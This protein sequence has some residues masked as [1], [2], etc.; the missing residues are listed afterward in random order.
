MTELHIGGYEERDYG[1]SA[2]GDVSY[3]IG[4]NQV[5]PVTVRQ[6]ADLDGSEPLIVLAHGLTTGPESMAVAAREA[7]RLG[8][9]AV[10]LGYIN[11]DH[12]RPLQSNADNISAVM[13]AFHSRPESTQ[14][15]LGAL[16]WSMGAVG[17][18]IVASRLEQPIDSLSLVTPGGFTHG[19]SREMPREVLQAFAMEGHDELRATAW[20]IIRRPHV[21]RVTARG[22]L[23]VVSDVSRNCRRRPKAVLG[24]LKQLIDERWFDELENF[25]RELP[26]SRVVL[27]YSNKD[28]L[29]PGIPLLESFQ[30][31]EIDRRLVLATDLV[32]YSGAHADI[33]RRPELMREIMAT[34]G[35]LDDHEGEDDSLSSDAN[36]DA[37]V[38]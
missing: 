30:A 24:E 20:E 18:V 2:A 19:I 22:I 34:S 16:G 36:R 9:V 15:K 17:Q 10:T 31:E 1:V 4:G 35:L 14:A 5:V 13:D 28:R 8:M 33:A 27:A 25:R 3:G 38:S 12:N 37:R 32:E 6:P 11:K 7:A 26:D 29:I 21:A 23:R